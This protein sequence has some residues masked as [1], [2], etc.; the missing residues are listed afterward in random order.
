MATSGPWVTVPEVRMA[1][2]QCAASGAGGGKRTDKYKGFT[3]TRRE[4]RISRDSPAGGGGAQSSRH[5]LKPNVACDLEVA[6]F[7]SEAPLVPG[8]SCLHT[9][10]SAKE[11][12]SQR[13]R[14]EGGYRRRKELT[15]EERGGDGRG[16]KK[17]VE[18]C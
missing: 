10:Q 17:G 4:S 9:V 15:E 11:P 6:E 1:S 16:R 8:V 18:E 12:G 5:L 14:G 3:V 7:P 2:L 13:D